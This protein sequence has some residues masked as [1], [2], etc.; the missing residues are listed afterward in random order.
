MNLKIKTMHIPE[1]NIEVDDAADFESTAEDMIDELGDEL[2]KK[3][4]TREIEEGD[5]LDPEEGWVFVWKDEGAKLM[6][7]YIG[8]MYEI[9][10]KY[11]PDDDITLYPTMYREP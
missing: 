10:N 6:R 11:F 4:M 3:G 5:C 9:G 8:K 7:E 2:Q 1:L